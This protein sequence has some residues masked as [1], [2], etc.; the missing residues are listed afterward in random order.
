M[1]NELL[2]AKYV[3]NKHRVNVPCCTHCS[4]PDV[5]K[6]LS[7][8]WRIPNRFSYMECLEHLGSDR[9]ARHLSMEIVSIYSLVKLT[10]ARS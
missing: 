3:L 5:L 4:C 6:I 10:L 7:F 9:L 1:V 2:T 8:G